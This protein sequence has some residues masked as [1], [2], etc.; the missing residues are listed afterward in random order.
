MLEC[1]PHA[2]SLG[3][4]SMQPHHGRP[5]AALHAVFAT[6]SLLLCAA[7]LAGC[8]K[9]SLPLSPI[10]A[11][12]T[13]NASDDPQI[14]GGTRKDVIVVTLADGVDGAAIASAYN[15][16]LV[17]NG[18]GLAGLRPNGNQTSDELLA[19][20]SKDERVL[21]AE[22][23]APVETAEARQKSWAFDDGYGSPEACE[24]Q[25]GAS[26]CN[27]HDA[28]LVS[29]GAGVKISVLDTGAELDHPWIRDRI[30]GGWDFVDNDADPTDARDGVDNDGDGDVDEGAGHGTHVAGILGVVAPDAQ[31]EIV[32]VLDS[33][34]RGDMLLLAQG[35]RWSIAH[36][37]K[38]LNMSLGGPTKSPAVTMAMEEAVE[39]G[40]ICVAAA[41]NGGLSSAVEFPANYHCVIGVTALD[42]GDVLASFSSAGSSVGICAPGVSVRSSYLNGCYA[43]WSGT[44]MATPWV[45]GGAALI[46]S[47]DPSLSRNQVIARIEDTGRAIWK[48]NPGLRGSLGGGALDL[49][50]ALSENS[51]GAKVA[52]VPE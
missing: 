20:V 35:I 51:G 11:R 4:L 23:N 30:A 38:V 41:G 32:R 13:A 47:K 17:S 28:L 42:A 25:P 45:A 52:S 31:L 12:T 10:R 39:A 44:S 8:S 7:L 16:T 3:D 21:T 24:Y 14:S 22:K 1:G 46:Y 18:W 15:A 2:V 29:R 26:S 19:R 34:G 49:G 43:L 37:V 9:Q 48:Q 40:V 33:D 27:L 5:R 6:S 50:A 36:G